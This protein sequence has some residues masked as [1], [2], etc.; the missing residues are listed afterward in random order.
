ML[1]CADRALSHGR[2]PLSREEPTGCGGVPRIRTARLV[3]RELRRADFDA[4]A[5]LVGERNADPPP[6][7]RRTAWRMFAASIGTWQL[8]EAGWWGLELAS[9]SEFI[10]TCGA[11]HRED[12][13]ERETSASELELGWNIVAPFR[14]LGFAREAAAAALAFAFA[15]RGVARAVAHIDADNAASMRVAE[16]IGMRYERDVWFYGSRLRLY[17]VMRPGSD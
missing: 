6:V 7:D 4:Y 14:R 9:T 11:F 1:A 3:L 5:A 12:N 8:D 17:V 10:G 13:P 2:R 15:R 16:A